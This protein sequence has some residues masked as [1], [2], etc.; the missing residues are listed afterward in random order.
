MLRR[1]CC[2]DLKHHRSFFLCFGGSWYFFSSAPDGPVGVIS[3]G[4]QKIIWAAL[5]SMHI[6]QSSIGC[7][8]LKERPAPVRGARLGDAN[9]V[10]RCQGGRG[11]QGQPRARQHAHPSMESD[12]SLSVRKSF[13]TGGRSAHTPPYQFG[14]TSHARTR[15][16]Y[17]CSAPINDFLFSVDAP[18]RLALA[19]RGVEAAR[20]VLLMR[21]AARHVLRRLRRP[22]ATLPE[23]ALSVAAS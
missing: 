2:G 15:K 4:G 6:H 19:L 11:R 5:I 21:A 9:R 8:I 13:E 12:D 16:T 10:P 14:S 17:F 3:S 18:R 23:R 7:T 22:R 20:A 1:W